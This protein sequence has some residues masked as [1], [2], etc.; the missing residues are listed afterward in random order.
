LTAAEEEPDLILLTET[1]CGPQISNAE[2]TVAGYQLEFD[3]RRDRTDTTAGIGGGLL[4]YSKIGTVLNSTNRFANSK[5]N[6]FVEFELIAEH[7]T[8]IILVYRPPNSGQENILE[9]C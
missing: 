2:L 4:V 5:F 8:K 7:P 9:L 3:L 1:W 6:Q